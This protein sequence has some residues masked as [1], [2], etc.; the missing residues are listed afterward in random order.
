MSDQ[1][2]PHGT[3]RR[4]LFLLLGLAATL[5]VPATVLRAPNA[6]AQES[7]EAQQPSEAPPKKKK[8][9]KKKGATTTGAA[10]AASPPEK[11]Q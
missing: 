2:E 11:A 5:A 6:E 7:K 4:K 3:S 9:K 8:K 1:I 10:P